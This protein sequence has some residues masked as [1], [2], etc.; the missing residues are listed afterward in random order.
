MFGEKLRLETTLS[1]HRRLSAPLPLISPF[2]PPSP[3][4]FSFLSTSSLP[5]LPP[6][7]QSLHS[8]QESP[9]KRGWKLGLLDESERVPLC[10]AASGARPKFSCCCRLQRGGGGRGR[11]RV[12][13]RAEKKRIVEMRRMMKT[14]C[15]WAPLLLLPLTSLVS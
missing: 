5:L 12:C 9:Q 4:S 14:C 8:G 11:V 6:F 2:L 7:S 1:P 10:P 13:R 15:V 3:L